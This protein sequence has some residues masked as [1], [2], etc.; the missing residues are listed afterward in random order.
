MLRAKGPH[1]I[2]S[3]YLIYGGIAMVVW[4]APLLLAMQPFPFIRLMD[5]IYHPLIYMQIFVFCAAVA[6]T[7]VAALAVWRAQRH[8]WEAELPLLAGVV[9]SLHLLSIM[10]QYDA[11]AWDYLCYEHAAQAI[12]QGLN[13]YG[14]CYIYVP[15]PAQA[16][17]LVYEV[18]AWS[19]SLVGRP[20]EW[21]RLWDLVFYSYEASQFY[22]LIGAYYLCYRFARA[23]GME[24]LLATG[25]IALLFLV[26]NPLLATIRHNQVNLWV[27]DLIL[28]AMLWLPRYPWLSGF[29]VALGGHIKLYPLILLMPWT[30]KRRW[31]AVI[32]SGVG[33]LAIL[34]VQT[35]GGRDWTLWR[36]FLGFAD[37]FPRGTFFRDNSLHSL[38][39]NGL[40]HVK[41]L[42][43]L[44]GLGDGGYVVNERYVS[45]VVWVGMAL[46]GA[47]YLFRFMGREFA[48]PRRAE[49]S[50]QRMGAEP[51][52]DLKL[53][54]HM[55]DAIALGLLISPVVWEHHYL[56]AMPLL[57]WGISQVRAER[58]WLV[59]VSGFLIFVI[60]TFDVFPLS[61]HRM[62]GLLLLLYLVA[63]L[64]APD[65]LRR[66]KGRLTLQG[67][68][69]G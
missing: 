17:A 6:L 18:G 67:A 56:L 65:W 11:R 54:G 49:S 35:G 44:T 60:P 1:R 5:E 29:C 28:V 31:P 48:A 55:L 46:L 30:L 9:V 63:P 13:P 26:N 25:V 53:V 14:N 22:L 68:T 57:I 62:A 40:G 12:V 19:S 42:M 24:R 39:Y 45:L 38:V 7:S 58:L 61:Y 66:A 34:L 41:W 2:A 15:T 59:G 20:Q 3:V 33:L 23:L 10:R 64:G 50:A 69:Q 32:S 51:G 36:Q 43:G 37:A 47:L 4:L 52:L 8:G 27:L 21:S 16:M